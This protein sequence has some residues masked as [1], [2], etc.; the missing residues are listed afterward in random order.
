M[1]YSAQARFFPIVLSAIPLTFALSYGYVIHEYPQVDLTCKI[2]R[3]VQGL[4]PSTFVTAA[5][6]FLLKDVVRWFSI[7]T[8]Q[9]FFFGKDGENCPTTMMLL[10]STTD[11]PI[12][13][14][15]KTKIAQKVEHDFGISL[16]SAQE[17]AEN[18]REAKKR[19]CDSVSLI[20]NRTRDDKIL[21]GYNITYGFA[22]NSIGAGILSF[23]GLLFVS[24]YMNFPLITLILIAIQILLIAFWASTIKSRATSYAKALFSAY[25]NIGN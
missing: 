23:M 18:P 4:I 2:M 7:L 11:S 19:I 24:L 1:N 15:Y 17:E 12:S 5:L 3:I 25:I 22:R 21:L 20:R 14:Q 8:V 9:R 10:W 13:S 6:G 16:M